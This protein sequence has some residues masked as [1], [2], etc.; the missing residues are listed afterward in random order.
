M[1]Q[2]NFPFQIK[3]ISL[4]QDQTGA[5][6]LL[7]SKKDTN[8][9]YIDFTLCLW[10]HLISHNQGHDSQ[11]YPPYHLCPF[12][13][14]AYIC[15]CNCN[16]DLMESL[17]KQDGRNI[18]MTMYFNGQNM[19]V[20]LSIIMKR[21]YGLFIYSRNKL[22]CNACHCSTPPPSAFSFIFE[23]ILIILKL[24]RVIFKFDFFENFQNLHKI[25]AMKFEPVYHQRTTIIALWFLPFLIAVLLVATLLLYCNFVFETKC[26]WSKSK[27]KIVQKIPSSKLLS[28]LLSIFYMHLSYHS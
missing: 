18:E 13:F 9:V 28:N 14:I 24:T 23:E 8:F 26:C 15:G 10:T 12:I 3:D 6:Y 22:C 21:S 19:A 20:N 7:I 27:V 5:V 17:K 4:P 25:F 16:R 11:N 1:G 2:N